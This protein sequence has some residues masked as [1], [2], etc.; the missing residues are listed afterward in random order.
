MKKYLAELLGT[1]LMVFIGTGSVIINALH[2][3]IGQLGIGLSFCI[4]VSLSIY[5][6]AKF[7]GAHINPAVSIA[8]Y[9]KKQ[10]KFNQLLAYIL[11]QLIGAIFASV[12]LHYIFPANPAN[13]G[14]TIPSGSWQESFMLELIL[15]FIL[16]YVILLV[17]KNEFDVLS[18]ALIIGLVV[19]LEAYFFGP[20]CG[21]S[22]NPARSIAP[23]LISFNTNHLWLYIVATVIGSCLALLPFLSKDDS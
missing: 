11:F 3:N 15:T 17:Q 5:L 22:M 12:L 18:S 8:F 6:F 21:A 10:L 7:S 2:S 1:F 16:M 9:F 19:G 13:L 23:A 4:A 20:I 14:I